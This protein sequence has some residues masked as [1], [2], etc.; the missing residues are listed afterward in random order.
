LFR[1]PAVGS[2]LCKG[3]GLDDLPTLRFCDTTSSLYL[4]AHYSW[5]KGFSALPS[6]IKVQKRLSHPP[7]YYNSKTHTVLEERRAQPGAPQRHARPQPRSGRSIGKARGPRPS[8]L[9]ALHAAP[10][11]FSTPRAG[12]EPDCRDPQLSPASCLRDGGP[13]SSGAG[14]GRS[15]RARRR[16]AALPDGAGPVSPLPLPGAPNKAGPA[17][18]RP[19]PDWRRGAFSFAGDAELVTYGYRPWVSECFSSA[20]WKQAV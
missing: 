17:S 10:P 18:V 2:L 13:E 12:A 1:Q 14:Q 8:A 3:A 20:S 7:T 5:T 16:E 6:S 19:L 4:K 9:A 15:R 11:G